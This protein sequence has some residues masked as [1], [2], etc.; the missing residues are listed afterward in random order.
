MD[1]WEKEDYLAL[2]QDAVKTNKLQQPTIQRRN[3]I[4]H[5]CCVYTWTLVQGK[6]CQAVCWITGR[7][8]SGLLQ[9]TDDDSKT[10]KP[11][12][13]VLLSKHPMQ[14]QLPEAAL[15]EYDTLPDLINIDVTED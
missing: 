13:K 1:L 15:E 5:V 11:V 7:D 9:P 2:V 14:S 10:G 6:L 4:E 8:K 3:T 12:S